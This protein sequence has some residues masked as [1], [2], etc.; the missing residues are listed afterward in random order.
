MATFDPHAVAS[1]FFP[2]CL[3]ERKFQSFLT[4]R[5]VM[6]RQQASFEM[7]SSGTIREDAVGFVQAFVPGN[8]SGNT[9]D[10]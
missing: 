9:V 2:M 6:Q 1:S 10:A 7:S 3:L 5:D 4:L 8:V